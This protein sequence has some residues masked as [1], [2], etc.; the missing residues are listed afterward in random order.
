MSS[1]FQIQNGF[2][3]NVFS[4]HM[5]GEAYDMKQTFCDIITQLLSGFGWMKINAQRFGYFLL[6]SSS[7][8]N[9]EFHFRKICGCSILFLRVVM[10]FVKMNAN[11]I[12]FII[13]PAIQMQLF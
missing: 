12:I 10:L 8:G 3:Q 6:V 5:A 9:G 11:L 7:F 1:L 4:V 13:F 2:F